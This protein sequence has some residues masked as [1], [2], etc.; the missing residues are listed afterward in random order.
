MSQCHALT[1][2]ESLCRNY[3]EVLEENTYSGFC[4]I[5]RFPNLKPQELYRLTKNMEWSHS[6]CTHIAY[7]L[8]EELFAVTKEDVAKLN[9]M[10]THT[11]F[12]LLCAKYVKG[13]HRDWHPMLFDNAVTNLWRW[14]NAIGPVTITQNDLHTLAAV[15]AWD[16]VAK[17]CSLLEKSWCDWL[18]KYFETP[19]GM[20]HLFDSVK[21][22][23]EK[24]L[25]TKQIPMV[26]TFQKMMDLS[27]KV[28]KAKCR[29]KTNKIRQ[30]LMEITWHPQRVVEWC[31]DEED[32]ELLG[33]FSR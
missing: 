32:K 18:W 7:L 20:P 19:E 15:S 27:K 5:H 6:R 26:E 3:G 21:E 23:V 14:H 24:W 9:Q 22:G 33:F 17:R 12:V 25:L 31:F 4:H 28:A 13:F 29:V 11:Y 10:N 2:D 8:Q 1:K 30:E 16:I